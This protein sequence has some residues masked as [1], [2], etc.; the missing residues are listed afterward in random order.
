MD[1][2]VSFL[3]GRGISTTESQGRVIQCENLSDMIRNQT[4]SPGIVPRLYVLATAILFSTG[5]AVIKA[6]SFTGWQVAGL[7]CGIAALAVLVLLPISRRGWNH[8]TWLVGCAY[9]GALICY[10]MANKMTTAASTIF[11]F[12]SS[13]LYVLFLGPLL[14]KEPL[15]RRDLFFVT[16]F[17]LG[18]SLVFLDAQPATVTAPEP[19]KGNILAALGGMFFAFIVMGLRWMSTSSQTG[20]TSATSALAVG[21]LIGFAIC[22]P[23]ALPLGPTSTMDWALISYLGVLQIGLAYF[24]LIAAL[25]RLPALEVSLL[26]LIEPVLN[27]IWTWWLHGERPGPL[28][29]AGGALILL[30]TAGMTLAS[31]WLARRSGQSV[32]S[33]GQ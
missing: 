5:G 9:A 28:T 18:L 15:R 4:P 19:L 27:P 22:L 17:I 8:R 13:P 16:A 24:L 2:G 33:S 10:A 29:L 12:S 26:I 6:T 32:L 30:V 23:F 21:N 7:R 20:E 1:I 3:P 31:A 14:L 25:R 11:L